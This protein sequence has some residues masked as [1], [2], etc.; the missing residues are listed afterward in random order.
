MSESRPPQIMPSSSRIGQTM[1]PSN[2]PPKIAPPPSQFKPQDNLEP[3]SLVEETT[4]ANPNQ[5][6][7]SSSKIKLSS[8]PAHATHTYKRQTSVTGQGACRVRSFHGRLSDE[9]MAFLDDKVNEWLDQHAEVEV[10]FVTTNIGT[11]E[12]KIREPAL[13]IN[14]WY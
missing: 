5:I 12:G 3:I 11:F 8:G 4:P 6:I 7:S 2:Q 10:K 14:V 1:P 9:G 13:I